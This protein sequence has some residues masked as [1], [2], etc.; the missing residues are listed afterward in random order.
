M[1]RS[2]AFLSCL[3]VFT[4][5]CSESEF[6]QTAKKKADEPLK[7]KGKA[8]KSADVIG[9]P[10][11][12]I[13]QDNPYLPVTGGGDGDVDVIGGDN[14]NAII[15]A[16]PVV[17]DD[18]TT[19]LTPPPIDTSGGNTALAIP[20]L[21]VHFVDPAG[22]T[23]TAEIS[24]TN[25]DTFKFGWKSTN[26]TSCKVFVKKKTDTGMGDE[27]PVAGAL[28][29]LVA[30]TRILEKHTFTATCVFK[31]AGGADDKIEKSLDAAVDG[32]W[33]NAFRLDCST[34]CTGLGKK[35]APSPE[36]FSCASGEERPVSS[37]GVVDFSPSGCWHSCALP[38]GAAGSASVGFRCYHP[39]QKRDNDRTDQT[40]GCY[41]KK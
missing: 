29:G 30:Q 40:T 15:P 26:T 39:S 27:R 9:E 36:G 21:D 6:T 4:L 34:F 22:A 28:V 19:V 18:G 5:S 35:S 23:Q 31:N 38:E 17:A 12:F 10:D 16:K 7:A 37:I 25:S 1:K 8:G 13:A 14:A 2:I 20:T 24:V 3:A 41:C 11:E 33:F 32:G